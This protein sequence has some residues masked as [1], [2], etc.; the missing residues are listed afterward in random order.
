MRL[1]TTRVE[2]LIDSGIIAYA[3]LGALSTEW[4]GMMTFG[5]GKSSLDLRSA[6]E[7]ALEEVA[8]P[9][10]FLEYRWV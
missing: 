10:D 8:G 3:V 1:N 5:G 6:I 2:Q 7:R 4:D 9:K